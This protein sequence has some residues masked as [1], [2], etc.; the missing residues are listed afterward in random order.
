M[1][2]K[3]TKKRKAAKRNKD[4]RQSKSRSERLKKPPKTQDRELLRSCDMAYNSVLFL[5]LMTLWLA[6]SFP[7]GG[8]REGIGW[9]IVGL[10]M[11]HGPLIAVGYIIFTV[12]AFKAQDGPL[13]G[14]WLLTSIYMP[15]WFFGRIP[16]LLYTALA[17][18]VSIRWFAFTRKKKRQA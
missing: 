17:V 12:F 11:V 16:A 15:L 7:W 9:A 10:I 6:Y 18:T 2:R 3:K 5:G 14:L 1:A 4:T 13:F 8:P